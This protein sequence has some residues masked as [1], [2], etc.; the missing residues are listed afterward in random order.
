MATNELLRCYVSKQSEAAFAELVR[1][2]IDLVYSTALRQCGGDAAAAQDVTQAVFAK[3]AQHAPRLVRHT[4][5]AGWLYTSTRFLAT[6]ARRAEQRR[7]IREQ[8]AHLMN[9]LLQPAETDPAWQELRPLLDD[10]MHELNTRDREAVLLRYFE[11]QPLA[12]VSARLGLSENTARMRVERALDK[13]RAALA[14]RGVTSTVAA[15]AGVLTERAVCVAPLALA[16][17]VSHAALATAAAGG[18]VGAGVLNY[19]ASTQAKLLAGAA[20][21]ALVAGLLVLPRLFLSAP[22]AA[23]T[24]LPAFQFQ[25]EGRIH[26]A[27]GGE[28]PAY[29]TTGTFKIAVNESRWFLQVRPDPV[30]DAALPPRKDWPAGAG[31]DF[32]RLHPVIECFPL[33]A[34]DG[35][36]MRYLGPESWKPRAQATIKPGAVPLFPM[37]PGIAY[38]WFTYASAG[39]LAGKEGSNTLGRITLMGAAFRHAPGASDAMVTPWGLSAEEL[40]ATFTTTRDVPRLPEAAVWRQLD[41]TNVVYTVAEWQTVGDLRIPKTSQ[42]RVFG[43]RGRLLSTCTIEATTVTTNTTWALD[44]VPPVDAVARPSVRDERFAADKADQLNPLLFYRATNHW[45]STAEV[46]A[47][48]LYSAARANAA[49]DRA[50]RASNAAQSRSKQIVIAIV[51]LAILAT[52][53]FAGWRNI[54]NKIKLQH[55]TDYEN[56]T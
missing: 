50:F 14:R 37:D 7:H 12:N 19:L 33:Q 42:F 53:F 16:E 35:V 55:S 48:P 30:P 24:A 15:L 5:L 31:E 1:Q 44:G 49:R 29:V 54:K 11:R 18:G 6:K 4:A 47:W 41:T 13:L 39:Y 45:P 2:H 10:V 38:V 25:V 8:E 27:V 32:S 36:V 28:V 51:L 20:A 34:G 17:H 22:A 23:A 56:K 26:D 43:P 46:R 3:L 9:E 52:P 21:T 40:D